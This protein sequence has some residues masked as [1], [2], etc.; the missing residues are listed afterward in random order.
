MSFAAHI[1][2]CNNVDL[3]RTVPLLAGE[4]RIGLLRRDNVA[5]LRGFPRVF[6]VDNDCVRLLARGDADAV[7]RAVDDVVEALVAERQIPKWRNET[8][9]VAPRWGDPPIFR[10]DRGAVPF[11]GVR[12]YGVHLNGYRRDHGRL[13]LWIGRRAPNKRVAPD[14]LDNLVAG[15]IGNGHGA[16]GTLH[17]EAAEEAGMEPS[18]ITRAIPVGAVTYRMET[19]LGIRDDVLFCYDLEV[20]PEFV[21]RNRDGEFVGF[22]LMPLDAVLERIRETTDFKFNVNLV[23]LDFALR[24]GQLSPEHPE[25]IEVASGLHRPLD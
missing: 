1:R 7:S 4:R 20:P 16:A 21:P 2:A 18:L 5:V 25:F 13:C 22:E 11:F 8:F 10:L 15:G 23:I 14:K 3:R 12:A 17:K 24:Y 19:T 6:A 9:D